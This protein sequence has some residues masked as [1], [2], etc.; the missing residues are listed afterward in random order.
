MDKI[1]NKLE[2]IKFQCD[3]IIRLIAKEHKKGPTGFSDFWA[4]YPKKDDPLEAEQVWNSHV[5]E[6]D[7]PDILAALR[8]EKWPHEKRFIPA[9]HR[10]LRNKR[11]QTPKNDNNGKYK[12]LGS[13]V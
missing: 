1:L 13:E 2:N 8:V 4:L 6:K 7:V 12:G 3:E 5:E 10:W 9:A 11:W